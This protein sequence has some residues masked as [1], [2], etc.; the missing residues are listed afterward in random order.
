MALTR[1]ENAKHLGITY[2]GNNRGPCSFQRVATSTPSSSASFATFARHSLHQFGTAVHRRL[3]TRKLRGTVY[4]VPRA[5]N[6]ETSTRTLL[7]AALVTRY[8]TATSDC[9]PRSLQL[10][11]KLT[12]FRWAGE[13]DEGSRIA[14]TQEAKGWGRVGNF[15]PR[16]ISSPPSGAGNGESYGE[17]KMAWKI[18]RSSQADEDCEPGCV[19]LSELQ[20]ETSRD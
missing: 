5:A 20:R 3:I 10:A 1:L 18:T 19:T 6:L 12:L 4:R 7:A 2:F 14:R 11:R 16:K 13:T 15:F 8:R 9:L 17:R